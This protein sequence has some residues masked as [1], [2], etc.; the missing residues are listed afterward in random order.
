MVCCTFKRSD[1]RVG[2]IKGKLSNTFY[3]AEGE[4]TAISIADWTLDDG[5]S[6]YD[7]YPQTVQETYHISV[8]LIL[9]IDAYEAKRNK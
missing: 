8:N 7:T 9:R 3:N 4:L 6:M 2:I 1:D 5:V